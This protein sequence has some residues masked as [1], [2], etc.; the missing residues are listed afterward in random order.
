MKFSEL[1]GDEIYAGMIHRDKQL[2]GIVFVGVKTTGI[3]CRP[4]C[5]ARL[6][7]RKNVSFFPSAAAAERAGFRPCLRCRP[8]TAPFCPAWN[9]TKTTVERALKLIEA[10]ALDKASVSEL[11]DR[12]GVSHR[13][14]DRLFVE[15]LQ[16]T[17]IEV[18]RTWR[19][20]RARRLLDQPS[21]SMTDIASQ[22][23]FS[24]PRRM[25]AAF[26]RTY[27][28]PPSKF[29]TTQRKS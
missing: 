12:L 28:E 5:K 26:V 22:S 14:L 15:H 10:G 2:D 1:S 7:L 11:S 13:H 4:V 23:G 29:R 24:G 8:E 3:Y 27:G 21:L 17:P 19:I 9:G 16:A 20:Q 6:P 25:H 18:A